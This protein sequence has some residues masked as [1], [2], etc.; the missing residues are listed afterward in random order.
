MKILEC[1]TKKGRRKGLL[2]FAEERIVANEL[3][4]Y[5]VS[6]FEAQNCQPARKFD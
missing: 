1:I 5:E 6:D 2:R 3:Q 4:L